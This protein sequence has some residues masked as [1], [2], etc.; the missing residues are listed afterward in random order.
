MTAVPEGR[1]LRSS[2]L[3]L[4]GSYLAAILL[5]G[6]LLGSSADA[7]TVFR[8]HFADDGNRLRDVLGSLALLVAAAS[9]VTTAARLRRATD[10]SPAVADL[11][12]LVAAGCRGH[13]GGARR[14]R[15]GSC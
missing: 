10:R 13:R 3:A 6:P 8:D 2:A 14:R 7:S 4:A 1:P 15:Q 11:G 9:L 5:L 12:D